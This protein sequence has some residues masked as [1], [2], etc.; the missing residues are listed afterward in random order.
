MIVVLKDW[1]EYVKGKLPEAYKTPLFVTIC[2]V[3][4]VLWPSILAI[5][6]FA[7]CES[8]NREKELN[9]ETNEQIATIIQQIS[10]LRTGDVG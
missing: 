4:V 8:G 1:R 9:K 6:F 10:E 3:C 7:W 5:L 2:V